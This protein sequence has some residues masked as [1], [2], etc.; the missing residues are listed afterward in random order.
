[1]FKKFVAAAAY[2]GSS[3]GNGDARKIKIQQESISGRYPRQDQITVGR[4]VRKDKYLSVTL[5][6]DDLVFK[7]NGAPVT[8]EA[9]SEELETKPVVPLIS[10]IKRKV[11]NYFEVAENAG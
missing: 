6:A 2:L 8:E 7:I 3:G 9:W 4:Q 1:M 5:F 11:I 10:F